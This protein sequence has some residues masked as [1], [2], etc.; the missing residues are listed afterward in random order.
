MSR[1][2]L[3]PSI[4]PLPQVI[5]ELVVLD[6]CVLMHTLTRNIILRLAQA[7]FCTP[8]WGD[9]IGVEWQRNAPRIWKVLPEVVAQEWHLMQIQFPASNMG[10]VS[11]F[12]QGL[13][14][15]D[16]KDW[17]VI[18]CAIAAKQRFPNQECAILT[19]NLKDFNRS[20][21]RQRSILLYSP[22]QFLSLLWLGNET[23]FCQLFEQAIADH[24]SIGRPNEPIT[25]LFK[26]DRLYRLSRLYQ[27]FQT[28]NKTLI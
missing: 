11:E 7:D 6:T 28:Q 24:I 4:T 22:D 5:P 13:K 18:A 2:H 23:L 9:Y 10:T 16:S 19:W 21:L 27:I 26:R 17:H 12:E 25:E 15:S 3:K 8:I 1:R 20:E 14:Q